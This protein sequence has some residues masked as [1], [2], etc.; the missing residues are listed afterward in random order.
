MFDSLAASSYKFEKLQNLKEFALWRIYVME[1]MQKDGVHHVL[2]NNQ[3]EDGTASNNII[4]R[5][6][7]DDEKV[8]PHVVLHLDD[9]TATLISAATLSRSTTK[10]P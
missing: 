3:P 8:R 5:W 4:L 9:E 6:K 2:T 1:L 7:R 10:Q